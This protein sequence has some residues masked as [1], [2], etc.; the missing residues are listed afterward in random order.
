M[1]KMHVLPS[2][3][4]S[5]DS[6]STQMLSFGQGSIQRGLVHLSIKQ[7]SR[8]KLKSRAFSNNLQR[9]LYMKSWKNYGCLVYL[10]SKQT[11]R[12]KVK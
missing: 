10:S 8:D 7:T 4:H 9:K 2:T 6:V 12:N 11:H 5:T 1:H 3:L